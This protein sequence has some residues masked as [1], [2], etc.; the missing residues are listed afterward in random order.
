MFV[1]KRF[2]SKDVAYVQTMSRTQVCEAGTHLHGTMLLS[3]Q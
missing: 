3:R 1:K 2:Y